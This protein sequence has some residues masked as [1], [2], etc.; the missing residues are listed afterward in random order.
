NLVERSA[1]EGELAELCRTEGIA[2]I[3]YR[4]LAQGFLTGKYRSHEGTV[5]SPRA[6]DAGAYRGARGDALLSAMDEIAAAHDVT[7]GPVAI[8]WVLAQPT[9]VAA[10]A[11]ARSAAQLA[12]LLP[13]AELVLTDEELH[14]LGELSG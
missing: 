7:L 11:S 2:C 3:G 6:A 12:E 9:V 8:A 14:R 13:G 5:A 1:Y 4:A 10:I